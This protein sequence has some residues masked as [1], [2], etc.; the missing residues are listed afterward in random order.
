MPRD[1][2]ATV[3]RDLSGNLVFFASEPNLR[4]G[5]PHGYLKIAGNWILFSADSAFNVGALPDT[6]EEI[7]R[8]FPDLLAQAAAFNTKAREELLAVIQAK[9]IELITSIGFQNLGAGIWG[10]ALPQDTSSACE[11]LKSNVCDINIGFCPPPNCLDCPKPNPNGGMVLSGSLTGSCPPEGGIG[12]G[13]PG[14]TD[15]TL[16][17]S[18]AVDT[19]KLSAPTLLTDIPTLQDML[20]TNLPAAGT[21]FLTNVFVPEGYD[22]VSVLLY[23][24]YRDRGGRHSSAEPG[25]QFERACGRYQPHRFHLRDCW[26]TAQ[27]LFAG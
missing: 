8:D 22:G 1:P 5:L 21:L 13:G 26:V 23:A 15:N 4:A 7:S 17:L 3:C 2:G 27:V 11:T 16:L 20:P 6:P 19:N 18:W 24:L 10:I 25:S 9:T 14:S 12:T